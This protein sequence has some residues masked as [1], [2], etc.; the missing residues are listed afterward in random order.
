MLLRLIGEDIVIATSLD[1]SAHAAMA[2]R[3]QLE[4]VLMNLALNARDAMPSGG[5]LRIETCAAPTD[6]QR[7]ML[8]KEVGPG[9]YVMLN[10]S[11]TGIGIAPAIQPRVFEPFFTTKDPSKGSGLGLSTVYGIV[12]QSGGY[13]FL[14]SQPGQGASFTIYFPHAPASAPEASPAVVARN[15]SLNGSETILLVEDEAGVRRLARQILERQGYRVL[16]AS[17]GPHALE[18]AEQCAG[19]I[20]GLVTDVVMP[21]MGGR[22]LAER[23]LE[24]RPD[25]RVLF[26]SGY[27]NDEIV[28]RGL[29]DRSTAF[30]PKPFSPKAFVAAVRAALDAPARSGG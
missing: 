14:D 10:V 5:T 28:R 25:L 4:Q 13:I 29:A 16:E 11:D 12:K 8:P 17:H 6:R 21:G 18:M 23:L 24:I 7:R 20:H 19:R 26:M 30:I 9:E 2:D 3:A 1:P 27:T 22:E 15:A